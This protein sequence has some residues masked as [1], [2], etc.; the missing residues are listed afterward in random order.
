MLKGIY[1]PFTYAIQGP[2]AP[3]I[4]TAE[5]ND[6]MPGHAKCS[7]FGAALNIPITKGRLNLGTWQV[8]VNAGACTVHIQHNILHR[9]E[10]QTPDFDLCSTL[11]WSTAKQRFCSSIW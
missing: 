9:P 10:T 1:E 4:H 7:M 6:D 5:G 11:V 8:L 3:W 2:S